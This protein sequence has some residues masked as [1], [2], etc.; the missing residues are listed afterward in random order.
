MTHSRKDARVSALRHMATCPIGLHVSAM[1]TSS[2]L[3]LLVAL[4][5]AAAPFAL[6]AQ[7]RAV[8]APDPRRAPTAKP[9]LHATHWLATT[10]QPPLAAAG[11]LPV[12]KGGHTT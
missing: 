7:T 9:P 10:P 6:L 2:R 11:A 12:A 1:P 8:Q 4:L 3:R 5:L